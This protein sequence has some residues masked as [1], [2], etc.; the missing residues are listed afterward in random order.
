MY[1][2][3]IVDDEKNIREGL[4]AYFQSYDGGFCVE[5]TFENA[6]KALDWLRENDCDVILTDIRMDNISGL[7]LAREVFEKKYPAKVVLISGYSEFEYA[8]KALRYQVFD[9]LLKPIRFDILDEICEK[10]KMQLDAEH[11]ND[12]SAKCDVM[13]KVLENQI[14]LEADAGLYGDTAAFYERME[15][16]GLSEKWADSPCVRIGIVIRESEKK[17]KLKEYIKTVCTKAFTAA[18]IKCCTLWGTKQFINLFVYCRREES[19]AE[20]FFEF[21]E[22]LLTARLKSIEEIFV[23]EVEV[24]KWECF[25]SITE[26]T[27]YSSRTDRKEQI[28]KI[29]QLIMAAIAEEDKKTME[30]LMMIFAMHVSQS[31]CNHEFTGLKDFLQLLESPGRR[32]KEDVIGGDIT[33]IVKNAL[34]NP[35]EEMHENIMTKALEYI[36]ENYNRDISVSEVA[37]KVYFNPAYF[38]RLFK[39]YRGESFTDY[40]ITKRLDKAKELLRQGVKISETAAAVGYENTKYFIRLFKK[41]EGMTP[42]VYQKDTNL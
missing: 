19:A 25:E 18:H 11:K 10:L 40:L 13:E 8:K 36:D 1:K 4:Y 15:S 22:N 33:D 30:S 7:D 42:G 21:A 3:I 2:L 35:V 41:R 38:G 20:N 32:G 6:A 12:I 26:Y 39:I 16:L 5:G 27:L 9:Y 28:S 34:E 17:H 23:A 29:E 31:G 14:I 24:E 37:D